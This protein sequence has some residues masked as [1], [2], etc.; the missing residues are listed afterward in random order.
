MSED[1]VPVEGRID[2][3]MPCGTHVSPVHYGASGYADITGGEEGDTFT[4]WLSVLIFVPGESQPLFAKTSKLKDLVAGS[5]D[6][7]YVS[8]GIEDQTEPVG[9]AAG[10]YECS[11]LMRALPE[12]T[13][14]SPQIIADKLCTFSVV[15]AHDDESTRAV[16]E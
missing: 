4:V 5:A 1:D 6:T 3:W 16:Q 9:L 2:I 10:D 8:V 7:V 15:T 14:G 11:V 12:Y 13:S